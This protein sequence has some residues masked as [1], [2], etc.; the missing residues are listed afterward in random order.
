MHHS[1]PLLTRRGRQHIESLL[2]TPRGWQHSMLSLIF[3][4]ALF[5]G[6][7]RGLPSSQPPIHVNPN[8][9]DQPKFKE[10]AANDF[11]A[12]GAAMRQP[13][14]GTVAR[15]H[16]DEDDAYW[17]GIDPATNQPVAKSPVPVTEAGLKRGQE[18]FNIYCSVCHGQ[19]GDGQGIMIRKGYVPPP[20]FHTDIMRIYPDGH[21]FDVISHGIRNMSAYGPQIPVADRWLIINYLRTLQRSEHAALTDVPQEERAKMERQ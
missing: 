12:D 18:R 10:Q 17:R 7:V 9:Y 3:I 4:V 19:A 13:V 1:L 21:I 20:S 2:P 5:S 11:F 8:M 14:A 15:G 6:C 16:L